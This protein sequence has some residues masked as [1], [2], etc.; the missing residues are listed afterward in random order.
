MPVIK[1]AALILL[2]AMTTGLCLAVPA[3]ADP[4]F[5]PCRS[6]VPF[7]CRMFPMMPDL[8]HDLDLTQNP[9]T[10]TAG[11]GQVDQPDAGLGSG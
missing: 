4:G 11:P 2:G 3:G 9:E 8:D 6:S 5:D 7:I 10:R 1:R